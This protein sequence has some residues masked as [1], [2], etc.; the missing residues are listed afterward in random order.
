MKKAIWSMSILSLW[1]GS[2]SAVDLPPTTTIPTCIQDQYGN[3]Y[4]QLVF[5][6]Q[7]RIITGIVHQTQCGA[8]WPMIGSWD[9][10]AAG[11]IILEL[12]AAN[13][14]NSAGCVDM[15]KLRGLYPEA[16]W[17]YTSGFGSQPF[18]Y[19]ACGTRPLVAEAAQTEG[20]GARARK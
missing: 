14:P 5:D 13:F 7:H 9:G 4:D 12:S 16:E 1:C 8:D 3:Q 11:Q 15:Y 18:S 6:V 19:V 20:L 10:D 2:A 17:N